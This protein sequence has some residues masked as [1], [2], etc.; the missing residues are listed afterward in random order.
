MSHLGRPEG[1]NQSKFSLAPVAAELES[2]IGKT[3]IFIN[4]CI[5]DEAISATKN[6]GRNPV[7]NFKHFYR[8][9]FRAFEGTNFR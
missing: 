7:N 6:P 9:F 3:V 4:D 1:R 8:Q 5:S 2:L